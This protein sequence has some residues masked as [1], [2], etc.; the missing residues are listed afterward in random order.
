MPNVDGI[1][2]AGGSAEVEFVVNASN[3]VTGIN[4]RNTLPGVRAIKVFIQH[5]GSGYTFN[6]ELV[7][8]GAPITISVPNPRRF[9]NDDSAL[10]R[11]T[12]DV[13]TVSS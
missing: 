7:F 6:S 10:I 12:T 3:V 2:L 5:V 9:P 8:G 13:R 4:I 1:G 11:V